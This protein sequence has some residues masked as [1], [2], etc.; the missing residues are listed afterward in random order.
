ML[1][2]VYISFTVS[3]TYI[4]TDGINSSLK[5]FD[6]LVWLLF[7]LYYLMQVTKKGHIVSE[8]TFRLN[9]AKKQ[10]RQYVQD[11]LA[12]AIVHKTLDME[13]GRQVTPIA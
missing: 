1:L 4:F 9:C 7:N 11:L 12:Q 8:S 6:C 10:H 2:Q 3:I 13:R 5:W